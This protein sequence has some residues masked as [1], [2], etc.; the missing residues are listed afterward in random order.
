MSSSSPDL[1][2]LRPQELALLSAIAAEPDPVGARLATRSLEQHGIKLSEASVSRLL[3]RLDSLGLTQPMGRKG[4]VLTRMARRALDERDNQIKR[5]QSFS[6]ALELRSPVE[7]LDWIRAR[8]VIEGEVAYLAAL[9]IDAAGLKRL[10]ED[11][12]AHER[13]SQVGELGFQ[14]IGMS[15]HEILVKAASSPVFEA[16]VDS[17]ISE[18]AAAA[19]SA[20]DL[21]TANHGTMGV[22][23]AEHRQLL[24]ALKARDP[25]KSREIMRDHMTRLATEVEQFV[26]ESGAAAF[27]TAIELVSGLRTGR[28]GR[29]Q[30]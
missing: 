12:A 1:A 19:E 10:E 3:T 25:D 15:F 23:S 14:S 29:A 22:S 13:A 11:V 27:V 26:E 7:V 21:I 18:S 5:N 24:D 9:R 2:A 6:R 17:L 4:R 16:I 28:K 30:L 8:R 20:L